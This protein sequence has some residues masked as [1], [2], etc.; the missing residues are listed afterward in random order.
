VFSAEQTDLSELRSN[1]FQT[2][3]GVRHRLEHGFW[4]LAFTEN[5]GNF[6]NTPD[7]GFQFGFGYT[8]H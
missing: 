5:L 1:K 2:S 6:N 3:F 8:F 4:S 7:I